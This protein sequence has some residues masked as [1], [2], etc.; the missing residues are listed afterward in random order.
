MKFWWKEDSKS[1]RPHIYAHA[2]TKGKEEVRAA[3]AKLGMLEAE[4]MEDALS[5]WDV[6]MDAGVRSKAFQK[7][8][9]SRAKDV[10]NV[11]IISLDPKCHWCWYKI[12]PGDQEYD[13]C[14]LSV[15]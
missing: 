4:G 15:R 13:H 14:L 6:A 8:V 7:K 5:A 9:R 1:G 2:T 12:R 11:A 10:L 3:V